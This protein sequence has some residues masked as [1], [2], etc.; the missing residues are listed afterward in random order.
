MLRLTVAIAGDIAGISPKVIQFGSDNEIIERVNI[1]VPASGS[2]NLDVQ[3][4]SNEDI[5]AVVLF[6][7]RPVTISESGGGQVASLSEAIALFGEDCQ[8]LF[9]SSPAVGLEFANADA[10]NAATVQGIIVRSNAIA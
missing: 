8:V 5:L 9:P 3:D 6:T 7:D 2:T 4:D 1:T 10:D